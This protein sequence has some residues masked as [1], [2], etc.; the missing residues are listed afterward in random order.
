M[1]N[2]L[3][4][5]NPELS[6]TQ[7]QNRVPWFLYLILIV[8]ILLALAVGGLTLWKNFESKTE[9]SVETIN[10][11]NTVSNV[12]M[13]KSIISWLDK[14][15][16]QTDSTYPLMCKCT[17]SGCQE[18]TGEAYGFR[19]V[20]Y[21][22]WGKFNYYSKTGDE[23]VL[24]SLESDLDKLNGIQYSLWNCRLLYDIQTSSKASDSLKTKAKNACIYSGYEAAA[25]ITDR[26]DANTLDANIKQNIQ[27]LLSNSPELNKLISK[28]NETDL[29]SN[30]SRYATY[31]SEVYIHSLW[32]IALSNKAD[33][34]D[35]AK[36]SFNKAL[37]GY[38][39]KDKYATDD[40]V[41]GIASL[42]LYKMTQNTD[43]LDLANF[44]YNRDKNANIT[45]IST[46]VDYY[47]FL[48]ELSEVTNQTNLNFNSSSL[49]GYNKEVGVF[50]KNKICSITDNAL[51]VGILSNE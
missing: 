5:I 37:G 10:S 29:V 11:K 33:F 43:Y 30:F 17:D 42:D 48:K 13:A 16:D 44:F 27:I 20:P 12:V 26:L 9:S 25:T 1:P 47:L 50:S 2:I 32:G 40:F 35:E 24:A 51:M 38:L 39:L 3:D 14:Q 21:I 34:K 45:D 7:T 19:V 15:K 18:C 36:Q 8:F 49:T 46:G 41:L 6:S 23:T 22:A 4:K 28:S 31:T